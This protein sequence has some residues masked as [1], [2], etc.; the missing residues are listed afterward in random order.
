MIYDLANY[1]E[2]M[3]ATAS[4]GTPFALYSDLDPTRESSIHNSRLAHLVDAIRQLPAHAKDMDYADVSPVTMQIA[5]DFVRR[6]PLNRALPK[7][8]VDDEGDILMR[9]AEPT[10]RCA[11]TVAHQVLHMTANPGSNSTHVE[12]L[13]YNG[14]HIPPALL[15]HIPI[16]A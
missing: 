13:V 2:A 14:G 8:A 1:T 4:R 6:L 11:L 12:P 10:G 7:V 9:W 16:R 3:P 15:Q 5:I